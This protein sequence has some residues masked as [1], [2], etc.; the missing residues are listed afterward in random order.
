MFQNQI[1]LSDEQFLL[2]ILIPLLLLCDVDWQSNGSVSDLRLK[3]GLSV[4]TTI[5]SSSNKTVS[6][7]TKSW[8]FCW[9][10]LVNVKVQSWFNFFAWYVGLFLLF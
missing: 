10:V 7:H 9:G 6:L 8:P 5:S 2:Q 4:I 1:N 3:K